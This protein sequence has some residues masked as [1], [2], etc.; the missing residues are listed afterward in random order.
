ME[1][2]MLIPLLVLGL[3]AS[4]LIRG[5]Q[6]PAR[7]REIAGVIASGAPLLDVRSPGEFASGH[8]RRA[9]NLPLGDLPARLQEI[10]APGDPVVVHCQS[11]ARSGQAAR[12]LRSHGF[13][14]VYDLGAYRN[15]AKLPEVPRDAAAA[16]PA[17]LTR[18]QRRRER[19]RRA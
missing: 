6:S 10:G 16:A 9:R 13:T 17:P 12:I 7:L 3:I 19:K 5:Y 8:H 14:R 2:W 11:G 18:N 15:L 4:S 1:L